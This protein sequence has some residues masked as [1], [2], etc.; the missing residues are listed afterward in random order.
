[1]FQDAS[2]FNNDIGSWDVSSGEDFVSITTKNVK[3]TMNYNASQHSHQQ[4]THDKI[5]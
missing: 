1:M 3:I 5:L 2:A 4:V